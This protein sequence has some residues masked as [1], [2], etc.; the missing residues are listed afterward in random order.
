MWVITTRAFYSV[1]ALV[2]DSTRVLARAR[3]REDLVALSDLVSDLRIVETPDADYRWRA[4]VDRA[5]WLAAVALI[6]EEVDYPNFK[7]AVAERQGW[8]RAEP[9]HEVWTTLRRL[10]D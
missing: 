8:E 2:D 3:A 7:S 9:L 1:V 5:A 10:Q 4:N 6:A